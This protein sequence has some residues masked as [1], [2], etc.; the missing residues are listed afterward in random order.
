[1]NS[2]GPL[3]TDFVGTMH[4]SLPA[5]A[6]AGANVTTRALMWRQHKDYVQGLLWFQRTELG[7]HKGFGLCKDEFL[8]NGHWPKQLYVRE[9][10]RMRG[11]RVVGQRDVVMQQD[12]GDEA[13]GLGGYVF[14][15]HTARRYACTPG[16]P[17]GRVAQCTAPGGQG[18]S[19][20]P[21]TPGY[22]WDESHMVRGT[23]PTST[24]VHA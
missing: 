24:R 7:L 15:T 5:A 3:G 18:G 19:A 8:D 10:R 1:M 17:P 23:S 11:Q 13:V 21:G 12:I 22:A 4:G 20:P 16:S 6:W 14:D 2:G 9:A